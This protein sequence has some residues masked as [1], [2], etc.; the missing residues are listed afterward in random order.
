MNKISSI[1]TAFRKNI[2]GKL[3]VKNVIYILRPIF[4]GCHGGVEVVEAPWQDHDVVNIQPASHHR[5]G[6]S[7]SLEDGGNFE[8]SQTS[9]R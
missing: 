7:D 8:Y 5:G 1:Y 6:V 3:E 4:T 9:N 2:I